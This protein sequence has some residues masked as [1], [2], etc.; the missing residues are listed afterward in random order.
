[1]VFAV[2]IAEVI[3]ATSLVVGEIHRI[4]FDRLTET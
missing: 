4:G 3:C 1:M 2:S